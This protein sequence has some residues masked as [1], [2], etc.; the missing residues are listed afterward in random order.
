MKRSNLTI[1]MYLL[2]VFVSGTV[3]GAFGHRLYTVSS[4]NAGAVQ[5]RRP[6]PEEFRARYVS[7]LQSRLH[8]EPEQTT[9]LHTILD[10]THKKFHA[11]R[12][13]HKPEAEKIQLEQR[14]QIRAM[15][16]P[17]QQS[18]YVKFVEEQDRKR[19]E[20]GRKN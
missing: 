16:N 7:D 5:Q 13:R 10:D 19:K 15:L 6:S 2:A 11:M 4:V 12:E 17:S 18:E 20:R 3:V 9:K 8:L 14:E 1:A